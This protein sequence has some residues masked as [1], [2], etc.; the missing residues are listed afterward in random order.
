AW[1]SKLRSI[2]KFESS[3]TQTNTTAPN[4]AGGSTESSLTEPP[5]PA[6][7]AE[8]LELVLKTFL[9]SHKYSSGPIVP[10][11]DLNAQLSHTT[12]HNWAISVHLVLDV[13]PCLLA[14]EL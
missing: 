5:A 1:L 8:I 13:H 10:A 2:E 4:V 3:T 14:L 7:L 9:K 12:A 11:Q 6:R